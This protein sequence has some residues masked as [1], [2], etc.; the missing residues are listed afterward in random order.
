MKKFGILLFSLC[1]TTPALADFWTNCTNFGGTIITANS[2]GNDK[3]GLCNDPSDPNLDDNCNG[4]SFCHGS[5]KINWWSAFTWCESLGGRLANFSNA[6]PGVQ[7]RPNNTAGICANVKGKLSGWVY[8]NTGWA[9]N[10]ALHVNS[11]GAVGGCDYS[12]NRINS[13]AFPLCEE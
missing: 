1:L 5:K 9:T 12:H 13:D 10:C 7:I 11:S 8:T 2:Y 3:G 4:K 6:C